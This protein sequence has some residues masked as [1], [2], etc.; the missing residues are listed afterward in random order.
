MHWGAAPQPPAWTLPQLHETNFCA[1][2]GWLDRMVTLG[3]LLVVPRTT[4][5]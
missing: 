1:T 4:C 2:S 3:L 5:F